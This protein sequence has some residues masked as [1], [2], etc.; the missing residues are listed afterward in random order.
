[1]PL[2]QIYSLNSKFFP[3]GTDLESVSGKKRGLGISPAHPGTSHPTKEGRD[4]GRGGDKHKSPRSRT[5]NAIPSKALE[6]AQRFRSSWRHIITASG[7]SLGGLAPQLTSSHL[8]TQKLQSVMPQDGTRR[9]CT[10]RLPTAGILHR[11]PLSQPKQL[12]E[13]SE[14]PLSYH[15][16]VFLKQI[17]ILSTWVIHTIP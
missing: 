5:G 14:I 16:R 17:L 11:N 15:V 2:L 9:A 6:P 3:S 7:P 8:Q 4:N 12:L 13:Q 10:H 1:M